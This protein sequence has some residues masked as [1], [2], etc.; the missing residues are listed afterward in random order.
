MTLKQRFL[1]AVSLGEL[2]QPGR[3]GIIVTTREFRAHFCDVNDDYLETFLPAATIEA[4]RYQATNTRY[5]FRISNGV[6]RVHTDAL[7]STRGE[8]EAM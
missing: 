5:M 3:F 1:K 8:L 2:G 6:Y 4:G 7:I